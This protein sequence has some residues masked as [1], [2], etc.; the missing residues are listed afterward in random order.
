ML[1]VE[2]NLPN[3]N[4]LRVSNLTILLTVYIVYNSCIDME[5]K[6]VTLFIII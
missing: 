1:I 3:F 5:E 4:H 2:A 6:C